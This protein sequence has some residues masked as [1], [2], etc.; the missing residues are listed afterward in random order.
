MTQG[1]LLL[2]TE[3]ELREVAQ[4]AVD[5]AGTIAG[6][7]ARASVF[8]SGGINALVRDGQVDKA[9]RDGSQMLS[10]TVFLDGRSGSSS[11]AALD[12]AS[13]R[14][15]V[16]EAA[17]IARNVQPDPNVDLADPSW[18]AFDGPSPKVFAPYHGGVDQLVESA[19][20]VEKAAIAALPTGKDIAVTEAGAASSEHGWALAIS[21]GFCRSVMSSNHSRWCAAI[22]RDD[23]G[24][25]IEFADSSDKRFDSLDSVETVA[26]RAIR[27]A[28]ARLGARSAP[29]M[30]GPVL[31]EARIAQVVVADVLNALDGLSQHRGASFLPDAVGRQVAADHV[32]LME[33]PFE[34]YGPA[35]AP[36]DGEGVAGSR[37]AL[38]E[39]GIARGYL[40]GSL[41]ARRMATQSSGN[42]QGA[43]N[44]ELSSSK[45]GGMLTDMHRMLGRGLVVTAVK[46][47]GTD[48]VT[49]NFTRAVSGYWVEDGAVAYPVDDLTIA[50]SM[51]DMLHNIIAIGADVERQ[52]GLRSGSIL[53]DG[54]QVGGQS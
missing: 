42:S 53:I 17:T 19:L 37:R 21:G 44:L 3:E 34:D 39:D 10:V 51:P 49:G 28:E 18:L 23:N 35:S 41:S 4:Q 16:E 22:A 47:G 40:H 29:A 46:G 36:F 8:A 43:Y 24:Q 9:Q 27:R 31:F 12:P 30:R 5:H 20:A 15:A 45:P 7:R 32:T 14:L 50:G 38:I 48:P 54:M 33:D 52:G 25:S 2:R 13:I 11:T 26:E 6:A 1:A